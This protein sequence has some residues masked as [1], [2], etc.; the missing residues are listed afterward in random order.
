[1]NTNPVKNDNA[2]S[3]PFIASHRPAAVSESPNLDTGVL[4]LKEL[5]KSVPADI[6]LVAQYHRMRE[7]VTQTGLK[8]VD[9]HFL[10]RHAVLKGY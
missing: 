4:V 1:M 5:D 9:K 10:I 2:P 3:V 8:N 6:C 7:K